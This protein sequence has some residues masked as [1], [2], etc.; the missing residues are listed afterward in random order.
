MRLRAQRNMPLSSNHVLIALLFMGLNLAAVTT[1]AQS[2]DELDEAR[3]HHQTGMTALNSGHNE[4]AETNFRAALA[5]L[6][7]A[8]TAFNLA[9]VLFD[10]GRFSEAVA[11]YDRILSGALGELPSN[12][13]ETQ[14]RGHLAQARAGQAVLR[15]TTEYRAPLSTQV[16]G[17]TVGE[18]RAGVPLRA[19][20]DAGRHR[21]LARS[22]DGASAS[23]EVQV[24]SG[25]ETQVELRPTPTA[26]SGS[27][28]SEP[29][30]AWRWAVPLA[31][32][33]AV[34]AGV[35]LAFA[36]RS[37]GGFSEEPIPNVSALRW[38]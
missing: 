6:P 29:R 23:V 27:A 8:S 15:L 31:L 36:L 35:G 34:G 37:D 30:R 11:F 17:D 24:T 10:Q 28:E 7:R 9:L 16:D 22:S 20:V 19:R 25:E 33:I 38:P 14:V 26:G 18:V 32:V 13:S 1:Q 21:I 4:V 5:I 2:S 3:A 12:L